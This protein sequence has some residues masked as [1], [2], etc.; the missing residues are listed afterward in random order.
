MRRDEIDYFDNQKGI[1]FAEQPTKNPLPAV[2]VR[3]SLRQIFDFV[4]IMMRCGDRSKP[5]PFATKPDP[6]CKISEQQRGGGA[7]NFPTFAS[8]MI[9]PFH[10][11]SS[12]LV[13]AWLLSF[14]IRGCRVER[15][16][17]QLQTVSHD[18]IKTSR[19][20]ADE[21]SSY[22]VAQ[23]TMAQMNQA[24]RFSIFPIPHLFEEMLHVDSLALHFHN[25]RMFQ[26]P[27]GC[28]AP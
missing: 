6:S 24:C 21:G 11:V 25:P 22:L 12:F 27:P 28:G 18:T 15:V 1:Y 19:W 14:I 20:R 26:H 5:N 3:P 13:F 9:N 8:K 23:R 17:K 16:F 2:P 10:P 7:M 4:I